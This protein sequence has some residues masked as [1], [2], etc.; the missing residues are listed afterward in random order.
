MSALDLL[1]LAAMILQSERSNRNLKICFGGILL[2]KNNLYQY[3]TFLI[4]RFDDFMTPNYRIHSKWCQ[5]YW[6][7]W[8]VCYTSALWA[9][10]GLRKPKT[11]NT[12]TKE[13]FVCKAWRSQF[14][15]FSTSSVSLK[16]RFYGCISTV[17]C[18]LHPTYYVTEYVFRKIGYHFYVL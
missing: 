3:S 5:K 14:A 1:L 8:F 4:L 7:P 10:T 12:L 17:S 9:S 16:L 18:I 13:M 6:S 2:K 15:W 11:E